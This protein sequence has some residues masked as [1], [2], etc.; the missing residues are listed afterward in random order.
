MNLDHWRTLSSLLDEALE[1]AAEARPAWLAALHARDPALGAEVQALL[2]PAAGQNTAAAPT[3]L[4]AQQTAF[5]QRL[6][7]ALRDAE[8]IAQAAPQAGARLGAWE[9]QRKIGEGGMGQVWLARRVDGLYEAQVA[10]KLLRSEL[11]TTALQARFA[12]ERSVLARLSHPSVARLLDAGIEQGQAYLVLEF[13]NGQTLAE[14]VRAA[15][16]TVLERVRLLLG[17]A[18]AV[19]HAHGQ[20][21]VHRDLKPS[22]VM[23]EPSGTPKLLDF[24]IAGLLD[25]GAAA[26]TDLTRQTGRGLTL[27]YAAPEQILGAPIGVTADVFSLGVMLHELLSGELPFADRQAPRLAAEHAVLHDEPRRLSALRGRRRHALAPQDIV[28]GP[29]RPLDAARAAGDLEA[30]VARALRKE[31]TQRY[32][33]VRLL[34]EDLQAWID[35]RPV[36]ARRGDWQH[37]TRLWLRRNGVL[38]GSV[39]TLLVSMAVGLAASTWQWRRAEAAARQ[40]AQVTDYLREMLASASPD[41]HGG[42]WPTVLQLLE[43]SRVALPQ[44]FKDDPDTRLQLLEV[45]GD[46]YHEL[47]R[48]DVSIPLREEQAALS[49]QRLGE[50][51]PRTLDVR[52]KLARSQ[53]VQGQFD[54]AITTLEAI[55]QPYADGFG[56]NS[57]RYRELLYVMTSCYTRLGRLADAERTLAEAGRLTEAL[58][59]PG[60]EPRLS[61]HNHIMVLRIGQGRMREALETLRETE[62]WWTEPA[63]AKLPQIL[64]LRRN[65]IAAHVR[66]SAYTGLQEQGAALLADMDRLLGAGNDMAYGLRLELAR[67]LTETG[68]AQ[69]AQSLHSDILGRMQSASVVNASLLLPQAVRVLLARTK[70]QQPDTAEL[71]AEARHLAAALQAD[72]D[73]MGYPRADTTLNLARVAIALEDAALADTVLAP[74]RADNSP[75]LARDTLLKHRA[76]QVEAG[77]AR[78]KGE[79]PRSRELLLFRQQMY[80]SGADLQQFSE[81]QAGLDLAWTLVLMKDAGATAAIDSA[82]RRRPVGVPT[83]HVLDAVQTYLRACLGPAGIQGP[84]AQVAL[85]LLRQRQGRPPGS[86]AGPGLGALGGALI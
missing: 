47:N 21:I 85:R 86:A 51:D 58:F 78:L 54:R 32:R 30:I 45:M 81:W 7:A 53:Q 36:W 59:P 4:L 28:Q 48:F 61:H 56:A 73:R 84:E 62:P 49:R 8:S 15:C 67:A 42:T 52:F 44:K 69:Q 5:G 11:K 77:V 2:D 38:A 16:P 3:P 1:L 46:T 40:S 25:D 13:V 55:Q 72:W 75:Q 19:D 18:E 43:S 70:A 14:H 6:D 68:E 17:I 20:L 71:K 50:T 66:V 82:A 63:L 65:T 9:L 27:A 24:G 34:V 57:E 37:R 39:A 60:S 29:G 10:I 64:V 80:G 23:V 79:L 35:H 22:N 12:R 26:N 83:G 76:A 33:S 31:A 74:L 41:R